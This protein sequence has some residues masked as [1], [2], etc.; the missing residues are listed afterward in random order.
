MDPNLYVYAE[1]EDDDELFYVLKRVIK[2]P[3]KPYC[4]L[5][6]KDMLFIGC[7]FNIA[8][9]DVAQGKIVHVIQIEHRI[10]HLF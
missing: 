7:D 4:T 1:E 2:L 9:F 8:V 5:R 3:E 6:V 10:T